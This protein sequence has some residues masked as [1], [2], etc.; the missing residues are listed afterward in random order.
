MFHADEVATSQLQNWIAELFH[1]I[2]GVS[3]EKQEQINGEK[4][5][6]VKESKLEEA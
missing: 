2:N 6:E 4:T 5:L 1:P 3:D